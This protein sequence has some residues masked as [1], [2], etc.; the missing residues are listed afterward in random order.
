MDRIEWFDPDRDTEALARFDELTA[1][2]APAH[3]VPRRV[4]AN[5]P[6]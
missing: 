5:A 6:P 1:P 2:W 4:R 3:I